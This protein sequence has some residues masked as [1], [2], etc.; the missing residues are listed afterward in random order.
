[1][2]MDFVV[3]VLV[4]ILTVPQFKTQKL[5]SVRLYRKFT[6]SRCLAQINPDSPITFGDTTIHISNIDY[7]YY[8]ADPFPELTPPKY[9]ELEEKIGKLVAENLIEDGDTCQFG[10]M[11][12]EIGTAFCIS[13]AL[14]S[15]N[16]CYIR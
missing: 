2:N 10:K 16:I 3:F 15:I 4:L 13:H 1:M 7:V 8:G 6:Y 14:I 12:C 5:L 11:S 9:T